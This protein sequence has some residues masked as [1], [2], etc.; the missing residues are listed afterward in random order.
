MEKAL[1]PCVDCGFEHSANLGLPAWRNWP[2]EALEAGSIPAQRFWQ[3]FFRIHTER[4]SSF[5]KQCGACG[6]VQPYDAFSKHA[7]WGPLELQM[8]CRACKGAINALLNPKRTKEQLHEGSLRRRLAELLIKGEDKPPSFKELFK[9]F[10]GRCFKTGIK[11]NI[12]DRN[13]WEMD[14]ILPAVW[15]YPLSVSNACLLS[16][17]ANQ[18]KSSR[19]PSEFYTGPELVKLAKI[20]GANLDLLSKKKPEPNPDIDVDAC[21]SRFLTIRESTD[22][23]KRIQTLKKMLVDYELVSK[24]SKANRQILGL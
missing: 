2:K 7:G 12:E 11:L 5:W 1:W 6:R 15:L 4:A 20:T 13:S 3:G 9:R 14:H 17:D 16:K 19:W 22:L 8:E 10:G 23:Q 18:N 21:V 24:L